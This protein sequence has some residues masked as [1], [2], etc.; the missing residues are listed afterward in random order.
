MDSG[1]PSG[2]KAAKKS[3]NSTD[4]QKIKV[5]PGTPVMRYQYTPM[6]TQQGIPWEQQRYYQEALGNLSDGR[7][8]C[9]SMY[10]RC[11]GLL[12]HGEAY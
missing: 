12:T 2:K 9:Y 4:D 5:P 10:S 1:K 3:N 6:E 7:A 11:S 8:Q